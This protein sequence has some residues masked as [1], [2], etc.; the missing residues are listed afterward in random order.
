MFFHTFNKIR[1]K[2]GIIMEANLQKVFNNTNYSSQKKK[3]NFN[4]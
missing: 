4:F 1:T 2:L 3:K